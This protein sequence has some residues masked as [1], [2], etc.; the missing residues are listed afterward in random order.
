MNLF[1]GMEPDLDNDLNALVMT[2]P[3]IEAN[4]DFDGERILHLASLRA[5]TEGQGSGTKFMND[6]C[7]LADEHHLY[8][9]L[10]P[11]EFETAPEDYNRLVDFY[12][13][14]GFEET[15]G[16]YMTRCPE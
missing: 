5:K 7:K 2:H 15:S 9:D 14:F 3:D 6:L 4:I 11:T 16:G 13:R 10:E 12:N 8:L 1:E